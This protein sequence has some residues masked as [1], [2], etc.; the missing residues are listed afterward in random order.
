M[1]RILIF[2]EVFIALTVNSQAFAWGE[3]GHNLVT[4]IAVEL[5]KDKMSANPKIV[6]PFESKQEMLGHISNIPDIYW[7]SLDK[8]LRNIGDPA[9]YIDWEYINK[10]PSFKNIPLEVAEIQKRYAKNCDKENKEIQDCPYEKTRKEKFYLTAGYNP[11]RAQQFWDYAT[12]ELKSYQNSKESD[13]AK[14]IDKALLGFGL[15]SHFIADLSNPMHNTSDYDGWDVNQGK[16]HSYFETYVVNK[17]RPKLF[18]QVYQLAL[19]DKP[20]SLVRKEIPKNLQNNPLA[21]ALSLSFSA[22]TKKQQLLDLDRKYALV[23]ESKFEKGKR[24]NAE[25]KEPEE[26]KEHF[27]TFVIEQ[28]AVAADIL[29]DMWILS[30]ENAGKPDLSE[31]GS[32]EYFLMPDFIGLSESLQKL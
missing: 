3:K 6:R 7:R 14:H 28:L 10:N 1:N 20:A 23:K 12:S 2:I 13:K 11:W 24:V 30:W 27:E 8:D 16:L 29:S 4:V 19:K 31:Y 18:D 22:Y 32:F 5:L 26:V 17:Y 9:H 25:R 15:M 21:I